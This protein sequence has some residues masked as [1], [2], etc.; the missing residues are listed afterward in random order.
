MGMEKNMSVKRLVRIAIFAAIMFVQEFALSFIPN[1]QLTQCLIA[2]FYYSLGLT[3]TLI[4]IIIHV[5]LDN[6]AM[7]SFNI[8]YTPAMLIGWIFLPI[9]LHILR[10]N[11]N[12]FFSAS[13]VAIHGII[14]SLWF[15]LA[16]VLMLEVP[17]LTYFIADLPFEVIL[18]VNGFV[19]T[20]LLKDKLVS[21]INAF[22][23]KFIQNT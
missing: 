17:F 13:V 12:R 7:G 21:L 20:L 10:K 11:Q 18:V 4:I 15:A 8:I 19:T 5:F 22:S 9:V 6:L 14:Y 3:D 2:V 23:N 16:N 1:I